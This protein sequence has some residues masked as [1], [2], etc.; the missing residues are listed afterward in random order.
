MDRLFKSKGLD[1]GME[2]IKD[3]LDRIE[4][5]TAIFYSPSDRWVGYSTEHID[6]YK[7]EGDKYCIQYMPK[8]IIGGKI[9]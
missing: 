5:I 2:D 6:K 3:L 9:R 8:S 1:I 7:A 4:G